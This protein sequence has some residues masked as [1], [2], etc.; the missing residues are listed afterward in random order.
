[1][2]LD[3]HKIREKVEPNFRKGSQRVRKV[4]KIPINRPEISYLDFVK[5]LIYSFVIL[6][7]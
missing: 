1:M 7:P 2:K 6:S 5:H 3:I 4:K